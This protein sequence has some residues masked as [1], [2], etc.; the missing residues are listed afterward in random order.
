MGDFRN[1]IDILRL[2]DVSEICEFS[3][4]FNWDF[5]GKIASRFLTCMHLGGKCIELLAKLSTFWVFFRRKIK[6]VQDVLC[7]G[8]FKFMQLM[9]LRSRYHS[10][11][12]K[13]VQ[14]KARYVEPAYLLVPGLWPQ[15]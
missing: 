2:F 4:R 3:T 5:L 10:V 12:N 7:G 13:V 15:E 8:S 9:Q 14:W 6:Q 1:V 11:H